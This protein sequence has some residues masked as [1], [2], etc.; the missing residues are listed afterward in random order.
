MNP[1]RKQGLPPPPRTGSV[2]QNQCTPDPAAV[3]VPHCLAMMRYMTC[4][5]PLASA[6]IDELV[7]AVGPTVQRCLTGEIGS[8]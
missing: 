4:L 2:L 1:R 6:S 7:A 5:E 3:K 8:R